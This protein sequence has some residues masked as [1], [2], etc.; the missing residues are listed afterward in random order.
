ME[1]GRSESMQGFLGAASVF[2]RTLERLLAE[3]LDGA[4]NGIGPLTFPQLRLLSLLSRSEGLRIGDVAAALCVS[5]TAASRAVDRLVLR[6]LVIRLEAQDDRRAVSLQVS[7]QGRLLLTRF[8]EA[9]AAAL[10]AALAGLPAERLA[11]AT[12]LLDEAGLRLH[13]GLSEQDGPCFGC[14]LF[15]RDGCIMRVAGR[16]VCACQ[17]V[18]AHATTPGRGEIAHD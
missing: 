12:A 3:Q 4:T 11:V 14:N 5:D 15:I 17:L 6:G 9:T 10:R 7:E 16:H 18:D 13:D 1:Q 2:A 8:E